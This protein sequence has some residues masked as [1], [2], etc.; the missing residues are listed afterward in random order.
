M[1]VLMLSLCCISIV[2]CA[3]EAYYERAWPKWGFKYFLI[4]G[5]CLLFWLLFVQ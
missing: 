5:S 3:G 1:L 2:M 4:F